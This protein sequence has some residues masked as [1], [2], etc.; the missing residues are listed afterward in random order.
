[1]YYG[2]RVIR[3]TN[4]VIENNIDDAIKI[5]KYEVQRRIQS[6]PWGI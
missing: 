4:K 3:F 5:I 6:P 2:A 1:M